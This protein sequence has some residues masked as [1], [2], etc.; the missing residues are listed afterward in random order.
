MLPVVALSQEN[1]QQSAENFIISYF[2]LFE[3]KKWDEIPN[4]WAKDAQI[5][6]LDGGISPAAEMIKN[7][8]KDSPTIVN[9]KI[10]INWI[11]T[12]AFDSNTAMVSVR[13]IETVKRTTDP[14]LRVTDN[15]D[16]IL[17]VKE[18]GV[19]KIKKW[20]LRQNFAIIYDNKIDKKYK[21]NPL[22]SIY[23]FNSANY[24]FWGMILYNVE[25][26]K[27]NGIT[28]AEAGKAMGI[29][30]VKSWDVSKGFEGLVSSFIWGLQVMSNYVEVLERNEDILK[31][32]FLAPS[33][34]KGWDVT[35]D[36]LRITALNVWSEIAN[37][38]GGTCSLTDDGDFW[39]LEF[40][41]NK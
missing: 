22:A 24:Q 32:R 36:E 37:G 3:D 17:V 19:W 30:F 7:V 1:L 31:A 18:L 15:V 21:T 4:A 29:R 8:I 9:D 28:P 34:I 39:V 38:M 10:D 11:E 14:P 35:K 40:N 27:K 12:D 2:K 26:S 16:V 13:Y 20:I 5:I 6:R 41:R 25:S 23:R 33:N